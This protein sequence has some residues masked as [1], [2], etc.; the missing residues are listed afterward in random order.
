MILCSAH[1]FA[2]LSTFIC[3]SA[4]KSAR[5]TFEYNFYYARIYITQLTCVIWLKYYAYIFIKLGRKMEIIFHSL[6]IQYSY[7][8]IYFRYVHTSITRL[9][10]TVSIKYDYIITHYESKSIWSTWIDFMGIMRSINPLICYFNRLPC[11]SLITSTPPPVLSWFLQTKQPWHYW[12]PH[13]DTGDVWTNPFFSSNKPPQVVVG[14][15]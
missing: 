11:R 13:D 9:H 4:I 15:N 7:L 2:H 1:T 6:N 5:I 3:L 10:E 12:L 14:C 8:F